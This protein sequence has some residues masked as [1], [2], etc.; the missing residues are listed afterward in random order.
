MSNKKRNKPCPQRQEQAT[1]Q[2]DQLTGPKTDKFKPNKRIAGSISFGNNN[3]QP[4]L[5]SF[6][7]AKGREVIKRCLPPLLDRTKLAVLAPRILLWS[8]FMQDVGI[9]ELPRS[10]G[11]S[12]CEKDTGLGTAG[13]WESCTVSL[14]VRLWR[15]ACVCLQLHF[16]AS[17]RRFAVHE[18]KH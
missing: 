13:R 5:K 10:T 9:K 18:E 2:A 1:K 3:L 4:K 8:L 17:V 16:W 7:G 6:C 11:A 14:C 12:L 15:W